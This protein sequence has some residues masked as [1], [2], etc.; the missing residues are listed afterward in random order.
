MLIDVPR[1]KIISREGQLWWHTDTML[2]LP[3]I[4]TLR[5]RLDSVDG[6]ALPSWE[7]EMENHTCH[8]RVPYMKWI[9]KRTD[10]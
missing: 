8:H 3:L 5:T 7:E 4:D 10:W 6:V 2:R 9:K 1:L